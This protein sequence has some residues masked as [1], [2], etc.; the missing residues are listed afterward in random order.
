MERLTI[1]YGDQYVPKEM[2]AVNRFGEADDCGMCEE[3]CKPYD[4]CKGCAIQ[5]CFNQLAQYENTG[6]TPD[7]LKI[8]NEEYSRMA[9]ELAMLR[10]QN[11]WIPV[12]ERLPEEPENGMVNMEDLPEYIVTIDGADGAT[13]LRYAGDGEWYDVETEGFYIVSAWMPLPEPYKESDGNDAE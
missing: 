6:I 4:N 5:K 9:H 10:Q 12:A 13:V 1:E 8:I 2:C 3:Y 7:Q 11:R